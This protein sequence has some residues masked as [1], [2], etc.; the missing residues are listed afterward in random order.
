M[1]SDGCFGFHLARKGEQVYVSIQRERSGQTA[2]EID[3]NVAV[4]RV[5]ELTD[6]EYAELLSVMD[7]AR[8]FVEGAREASK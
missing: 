8:A 1:T 5:A 6:A 7:A 4:M 3:F 2:G